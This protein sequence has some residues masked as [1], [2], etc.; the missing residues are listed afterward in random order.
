MKELLRT[1]SG[2]NCTLTFYDGKKIVKD[3]QLSK[4]LVSKCNN[5]DIWGPK[6]IVVAMNIQE[7]Q[8]IKGKLKETE[9][10]K[11][12][13]SPLGAKET[14]ELIFE[15]YVNSKISDAGV[16]VHMTQEAYNSI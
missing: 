16:I 2:R 10:Q 7:Y 11:I 15:K 12:F 1:D 5:W 8:S 13:Q 6:G 9:M 3:S 4:D 14:G